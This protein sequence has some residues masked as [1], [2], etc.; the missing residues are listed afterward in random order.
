M[1]VSCP[2]GSFCAAVDESGNVLISTDQGSTWTAPS[3]TGN[4]V[5]PSHNGMNSISCP[6][7]SFCVAVDWWGYA[8]ASTS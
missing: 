1:S 2:S 4:P 6:T 7:V 3:V 5:D 8:F